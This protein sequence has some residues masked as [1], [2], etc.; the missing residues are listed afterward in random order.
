MDEQDRMSAIA[1]IQTT[2]EAVEYV[3]HLFATQLERSMEEKPEPNAA[4]DGDHAARTAFLTLLPPEEQ[5]RLMMRMAGDKKFWPRIRPLIGAPPFTFLR[6][7]DQNMLNASGIAHGRV[8]MAHD[9]VA[10]T[11]YSEFGHGHF[12][13]GAGRLY[14]VVSRK[15]HSAAP[16][17]SD[18]VDGDRLVVD[19]RV[20]RASQSKKLAMLKAGRM[21]AT[22]MMFPRVGDSVRVV[23]VTFLQTE[24]RDVVFHVELGRQAKPNSAVARLVVRV[25]DST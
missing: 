18:L 9:D 23:P 10:A 2:A 3:L 17:W 12:Q 4:I 21:A 25:L 8:N 24:P 1:Q 22:A 19:V 15:R 7:E 5:R 16:L 20:A 6:P 11:S 14:R 13:D